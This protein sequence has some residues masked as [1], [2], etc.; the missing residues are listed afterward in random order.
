MFS[1]TLAIQCEFV[2]ELRRAV[3]DTNMVHTTVARFMSISLE[4]IYPRATGQLYDSN[5]RAIAG[6]TNIEHL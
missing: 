2:Y 5:G 6:V 4:A 3:F 1:H